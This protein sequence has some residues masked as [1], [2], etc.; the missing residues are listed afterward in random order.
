MGNDFLPHLPSLDIYGGA[1]DLLIEKYT[2]ILINNYNDTLNIDYIINR[3]SK[4]KINQNIFNQLIQEL[5]IDEE[6]ILKENYLKDEKRFGCRS[7][8]PYDR[9]I[10]RIENLRFKINDPVMLGKDT[11]CEWKERYYDHYFHV[12]KDEI[13]DYS[14][15]MVEHYCIGLKWITEYYFDKCPSWNWYF[16]YDHP[17]FLEDINKYKINFKDIDFNIGKP[18]LPFQQLLCILPKESA[19]LV[20]KCL[21]KIMLNNNSSIAH[22]YPSDFTQDFINKKQYWMGI[23]NLPPLEIDLVVSVYNKYQIKLNSLEREMNTI[24]DS[25]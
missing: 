2:D 12:S 25:P 21:Q 16:P 1:I 13:D 23:P 11:M 9:E 20:P 19:Y 15:K 8:D 10:F 6:Q 14:K 22:L 18:L 3:N 7:K 4:N 24:L 5:S 17:P